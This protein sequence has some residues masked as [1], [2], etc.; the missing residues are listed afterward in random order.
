ML[1]DTYDHSCFMARSN[2]CRHVMALAPTPR[3]QGPPYEFKFEY[4]D[5]NGH[6]VA[7]MKPAAAPKV[8]FTGLT[9][10]SQVDPAV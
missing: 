3:F 6:A 2:E 7:D 9:Q 10:N 8:K 5:C 1:I 4:R